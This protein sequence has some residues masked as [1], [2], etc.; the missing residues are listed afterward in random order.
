MSSNAHSRNSLTILQWVWKL[1]RSGNEISR[2]NKKTYHI[3]PITQGKTASGPVRS[4]YLSRR[5]TDDTIAEL[6]RESHVN[7]QFI[8]VND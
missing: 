7:T 6:V 5:E 4:N 2:S 8:A 3:R 1:V